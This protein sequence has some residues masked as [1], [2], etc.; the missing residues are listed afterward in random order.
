MF[1]LLPLLL[2]I[3]SVL[4]IATI[5]WRKKS[6]VNNLYSLNMAGNDGNLEGVNISNLGWMDY[7]TEFFPE[8]KS[9][10]DKFELHKHKTLW[11]VETEKMLR[12]LRVVFLRIDRLSD[13]LI[14]KIRKVNLNGQLKSQAVEKPAE[15]DAVHIAEDNSL[16][17]SA[18]NL[19]FLKNE[20]ERL[21]MEIA[22][23]PKNPQL[24]ESL[25][26][27]Y[28]EMESFVDAKESYEAAIELSPQNES[29]GQK[30]SSALVKLS[31]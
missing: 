1:L 16:K 24:Y 6:H 22:K 15:T 21:I 27:L 23:N 10:Y 11:L 29:L 28:M 3:S 18:I 25:G 7:G 2:V 5:I 19:N 4:G 13:M 9:I 12:K 17:S 14:K 30:L 20:E 31:E 26:D 8:I